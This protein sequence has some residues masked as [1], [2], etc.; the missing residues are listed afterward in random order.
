MKYSFCLMS[1][2]F[3]CRE[4]GVCGFG[5]RMSNCILQ[6]RAEFQA[7]S[8]GVHTYIYVGSESW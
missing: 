4:S 1:L 8:I 2:R 7:L 3:V 6:L 5:E